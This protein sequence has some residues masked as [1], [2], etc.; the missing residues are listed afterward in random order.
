MITWV[1]LNF[2]CK[3]HYTKSYAEG[4]NIS[5]SGS[6]T[7]IDSQ[8]VEVFL[9]Y[10]KILDKDMSKVIAVAEEK[11]V[12]EKPE[13]GLTNFLADLLLEQGAKKAKSAGL[14]IKPDISY[15]N[16][17]GIR[18]FL[19]E[20]EITVGKIYE[21]M[22]FENEMVYLRLSGKQVQE[23]LNII[24]EKGGDSL[25]GVRFVISRGKAENIQINGEP[26]SAGSDYWLVTNDYVASGGDNLEVLTK[27]SEFVQSG[28]KIRNVIISHLADMQQKEKTISAR[29]DERI[30]YE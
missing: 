22:P 20:G 5:V 19:P 7:G 21:L 14:Q 9:P 26:L 1:F 25:G 18:T 4:Q 24:A 29:K 27:R 23:F 10:E 16:Y 2:S 3:T 30:R 6:T 28:E 12:K 13:S 11:M 8:V 15:F 17:G